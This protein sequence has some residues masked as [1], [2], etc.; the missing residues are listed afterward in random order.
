MAFLLGSYFI[1]M[2]QIKA[3]LIG[4][5]WFFNHDKKSKFWDLKWMVKSADVNFNELEE[6][7]I[8]N[9]FKGSACITTKVG[10]IHTLSNTSFFAIRY[11]DQNDFFPRSYDLSH[12]SGLQSFLDDY[13]CLQAESILRRL[14]KNC[15]GKSSL[16]HIN[17]GVLEILLSVLRKKYRQLSNDSFIDN[18]RSKDEECVAHIQ[19]EVLDHAEEWLYRIVT[20]DDFEITGN[21]VNG[22][23]KHLA[24]QK[25]GKDEQREHQRMIRRRKRTL[26]EMS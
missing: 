11:Q 13:Y 24:K 16:P 18:P 17:L 5:G 21:R 25:Q 4:R 9:H 20:E 22:L 2:H 23:E 14:M 8:V 1:V 15:E 19:N 26:S 6:Y 7:Q 12:S 3:D 10:L